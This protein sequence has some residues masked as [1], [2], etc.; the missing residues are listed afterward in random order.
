M[1][2][3]Q[4]G[5][6]PIHPGEILREEFMIP[7]RF[8]AHALAISLRVSAP[9]INDIARELRAITANTALRFALFFGVSVEFWTGFQAD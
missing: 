3:I 5:M 1:M 9:R 4:D 8:S 2:L 6:R 7:M